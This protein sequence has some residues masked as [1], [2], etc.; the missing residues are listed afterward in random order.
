MIEDVAWRQDHQALARAAVN[1]PRRMV[2]ICNALGLY[3]G[4]WFPTTG[5][6]VQPRR[7]RWCRR[8]KWGEPNE[9]RFRAGRALREAKQGR[10][11]SGRWPEP[12]T[13]TASEVLDQ[14]FLRAG[15]IQ[16]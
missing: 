4:S 16:D 2:N 12:V 7:S 11:L 10:F 9:V 1:P 13:A 6:R 3:S 14:V 15:V 5:Y 8:P